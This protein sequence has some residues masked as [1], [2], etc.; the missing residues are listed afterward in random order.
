MSRG[1]RPAGW[2]ERL[3]Q[4][5]APEAR[6]T[7]GD[8]VLIGL[9]SALMSGLVEGIALTIKHVLFGEFVWVGIDVLWMSPLG[10]VGFFLP[11]VVVLGLAAVL[12]PRWLPRGLVLF[13]F[14]T[15]A[16]FPLLVFT[17]YTSLHEAS[18]FL[19]AA[20]IAF[21]LSRLLN[22]RWI[23]LRPRVRR[24][25]LAQATIV[26]L[27]GIGIRTW[28]AAAPVMTAADLEPAR[29][30]AL[31]IVLIIL[32]TVRA[33]TW[34]LYGYDRLTTPVMEQWAQRAIVFETALATTSWTL[35]SHATMLTGYRSA[36]LSTSWL[37]PLDHTHET[38]AERLR[39]AGY[40]T[41]GFVAN[42]IYT[43]R[44]TGLDRGFLQWNDYRVS[45]RQIRLSTQYGQ[46]QARRRFRWRRPFRY[47]DRKR[48]HDVSREFLD[49]LDRRTG[50]D[51]PF[52]ALLNYYDAHS[53]YQA[54]S[55]LRRRF[56]SDRPRQVNHYDAAVAYLD[57]EIGRLLN[58]LESRELLDNTAIIV[59]SDHGELLGEHGLQGHANGL[60]L[61]L[62]HVP[63]VMILPEP[64]PAG[65][66]ITHPVSLVNLAAT[67]LDIA[68]ID[69]GS[70]PGIPIT[71]WRQDPPASIPPQAFLA[72][73]EQGIRRAPE[74]PNASGPMHSVLRS[75]LH[76]I[77]NGDGT[78]E[79]FDLS[80]DPHEDSNLSHLPAWTQE[81][82]AFRDY[83]A[84]FR[85]KTRPDLAPA[86][87]D[88]HGLGSRTD[89]RVT[90]A[91]YTRPKQVQDDDPRT[92]P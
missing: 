41:A 69:P 5:A 20:G 58:E 54:S 72:E 78:E 39:D 88:I 40:L 11:G 21:Q 75:N 27:A 46:M 14:L 6:A 80:V 17:F 12:A 29:P 57:E 49:W 56:D 28:A 50:T 7:L 1:P 52:F 45:R 26:L 89:G 77:I 61:P 66:R 68:G 37:S 38:V 16:L 8:V 10:Y 43:S 19:L 36:E 63:L 51:H 31:N 4:G 62:L 33:A 23:I 42:Y 91:R 86:R 74:E 47:N 83:I 44:E 60:Y 30:G 15:A 13:V 82:G 32:D 48:G 22:R 24:T 3:T 53:P 90:A 34:S 81:I 55:A 85:Y 79:L 2:R 92:T 65:I 59:T 35:P 87:I 70:I 84:D 25:L 18:T 9:G 73:L 67:M 71:L 64:W 76:Y